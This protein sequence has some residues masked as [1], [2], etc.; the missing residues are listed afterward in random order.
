[1]R[2]KDVRQGVV[3][4]ETVAVDMLCCKVNHVA[5]SHCARLMLP[6]G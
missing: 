5:D 4:I 1:V 2:K 3:I 6:R